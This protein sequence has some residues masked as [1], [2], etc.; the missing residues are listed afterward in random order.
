[1]ARL[2]EWSVRE[3][4]LEVERGKAGVLETVRDAPFPLFVHPAWQERFPWLLQG[5]TGRGPLQGSPG[6]GGEA[7]QQSADFR[8]FGT[9]SLQDAL[10]SWRQ[11]R[12]WSAFPLV[13]HS[14]QPHGTAVLVHR[15]GGQGL[16]LGPDA[17]GHLTSDPGVLLTITV[18]DCVPVFAV[19]P[20]LPAVGLVHAGWRGVARGALAT[21]LEELEVRLGVQPDEAELHL[22]P[23]ICGSCYQVGRDVAKALGETLPHG[24]AE[25]TVD[26]RAILLRQ[27][28]SLGVPT[29]SV[30]VSEHCTLCG[31]GPFY[32][33]RGGAP[34][35]QVAI[36]GIRWS[37]G[38]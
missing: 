26:L 13:A 3:A 21:L 17:D 28:Q 11:L 16:V 22:G 29:G 20:H 34:R 24:V 10:L 36:L 18:A 27:A 35:R 8:L 32:S 2:E 1:M 31:P 9:D 37:E 5:T 6:A 33:H 23:A 38:I 30:S 19:V 14:R 7:P 12:E 25:G 15:R 4:Q